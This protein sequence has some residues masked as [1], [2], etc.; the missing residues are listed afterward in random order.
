MNL[1][2][3]VSCVLQESFL[4]TVAGCFWCGIHEQRHFFDWK[5][6]KTKVAT[7]GQSTLPE[8]IPLHVAM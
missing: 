8:A 7:I 1:G 5:P 3:G 2:L 4:T 6:G